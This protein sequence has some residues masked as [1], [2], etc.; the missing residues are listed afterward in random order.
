LN[1][2]PRGIPP[3]P[4][5]PARLIVRRSIIAVVAACVV[6][7]YAWAADPGHVYLG[8]LDADS[9]YYYNLLIKGFRSGHLYL[10]VKPPAELVNAKDPY[11]TE[12]A[13]RYGI[14]DVSYFKGRYYLYFGVAPALALYWPFFALTGRYLDDT[15]AVF[16]FCTAAFLAG[17]VPL[18]KARRRYFPALG[19]GSDCGSMVAMGL[20][21]MIP[22]LLRRTQIYEVAISAAYLFFILSLLCLYQSLHARRG[23]AWLAAAS[24]C[25]GLAIASRAT[26]VFGAAC[27]LVPVW[28]STKGAESGRMR[29]V[30]GP[31][32][33]ACAAIVPVGLVVA[34]LLLY[35]ELRFGNPFEF[36]QRLTLS[37]VK[38]MGRTHFSLSYIWFNCRAYLFAP[39]NLSTF[40]PFVRVVSLPGKPLEHLGVE[41]P[42]GIFPNIPFV[43][44]AFATPLAGRGRPR[45]AAFAAAAAVAFLAVA[46]IVFSF[47]FASN[48]YMVDFLPGLIVLAVIGSWGLRTQFSGAA[49]KLA[50]AG[51]SVLLAWSVL[52][53]VFAAFGHNDLLRIADPDS[54]RVL[55]HAFGLPRHYV[56]RL[57]GRSYGP[58][59]LTVRFPKFE[60]AHL[61]PLVI[62]GS[63]FLSDYLYLLYLP[64]NRLI[65]GFEHTGYG[66]AVTKP[67]A[68]DYGRIHRIVVDMAPLYPPKDDPYFDHLPKDVV[69]EALGHLRVS[70]DG[71]PIEDVEQAT[72]PPFRPM[73]AVGQ[74]TESQRALGRSFTGEILRVRSLPPDWGARPKPL[75]VGPIVMALTFPQGRTGIQE[76]LV[77]SGNTGHGD[78]LGVRYV[79]ASHVVLFL[80]H[81]G[82]GGPHTKPLA[83]NPDENQVFEV[84]F[85]SFFPRSGRPPDVPEK[86]WS[87]ASRKLVVIFNDRTVLNEDFGFYDAR[88]ETVVVGKNPIGASTCQP[89]FTGKILGYGRPGLDRGD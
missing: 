31:L 27:L 5:G 24:L 74:G 35:N 10:A 43:L 58:I 53:N 64:D 51:C 57:R 69:A 48:R 38:E 66:G 46:A 72:Y 23:M 71:A 82:Y 88:P 3:H 62:S 84:R 81:W 26:Y 37:G 63:E 4:P 86:A 42:Y 34:A 80:D 13:V 12:T 68:C 60:K 70:M 89:S 6:A 59:E 44:L 36:G 76:P 11:D 8:R 15:Q 28:W 16:I 54:F 73:P 32:A 21:A 30:E 47:E 33:R 45:L 20:T 83:F 14:P 79:D 29:E 49:R 56:D 67:F 17:S 75:T 2:I 65:V 77:S 78:V 18:I 22:V 40:F 61:E 9:S 85:G 55:S 7:F 87:D 1:G 50:T 19:L 25:Y 41:D 39:A 52:F